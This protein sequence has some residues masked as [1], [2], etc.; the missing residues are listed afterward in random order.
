MASGKSTRQ[1]LFTEVVSQTKLPPPFASSL[2]G[3]IL[4]EII[5]VGHRLEVMDWAEITSFHD[6][7]GD[8]DHR[9]SS[10]EGRDELLSDKG[11]E[12]RDLRDKI[13]DLEGWRDNVSF[14]GIP[15][16]VEGTD[17]LGF[18]QDLLPILVVTTFLS[19]LEIQ[20]AHRIKPHRPPTPLGIRYIIACILC[21]KQLWQIL[22]AARFPEPNDFEGH[23]IQIMADFSR[24]T[25]GKRRPL[26][27]YKGLL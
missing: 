19:P 20:R 26:V 22:K 3:Q 13:T 27:D 10:L 9:L 11:Q 18:L 17:L 12:L 2:E 5:A 23:N 8:L 25:D 6:K 4:K 21:H 14:F 1:L 15:E 7:V 24:E 16:K